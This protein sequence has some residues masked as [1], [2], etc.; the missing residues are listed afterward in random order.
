MSEKTGMELIFVRYGAGD[1][2]RKEMYTLQPG[3]RAGSFQNVWRT[4]QPRPITMGN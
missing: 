2:E 3:R 4:D 1:F